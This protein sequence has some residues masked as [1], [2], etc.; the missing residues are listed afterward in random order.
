M[1][2]TSDNTSTNTSAST[3]TSQA[4]AKQPPVALVTGAAR[5]IGA[6][7]ADTLHTA[8][9]NI[10]IHYHRSE[11]DAQTL[12]DTLNQKRHDSARLIQADLREIDQLTIL[13]DTAIGHWG[14]L[15]ALVNNASSFYPTAVGDITQDHYRDLFGTNVAAPLFLSQACAPALRKSRGCIVNIADIH[16]ER[17]LSGYPVYCAA[18]AAN[19]MLTKSLARE[20]APDVRVNAVAPGAILLPEREASLSREAQKTI[21]KRTALKRWGDPQDIATTI[22][23]LVLEA[24]YITGQV[25]PVDGGRNL[26]S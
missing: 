20:L 12:A 22:K 4:S 25:I 5:R 21:L 2:S 18:K 23:F 26:V 19:V 16:A 6:T 24:P 13:A 11:A 17:P 10:L 9:F 15:D 7:I 1:M 3:S 8:G 14:R